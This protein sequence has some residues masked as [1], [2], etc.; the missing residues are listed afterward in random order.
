MTEQVDRQRILEAASR[1]FMEMGISKVTLDEIAEELR[2]SKKTMYRYFP[3]KDDLLRNIIHERIKRN[4]QRLTDIMT[5]G[6]PL[7]EK[8]QEIFAFVGREFSGVSRQF[9]VDL[10][11]LSP[12]LWEEAEEFRRKTIVSNVRK[13]IEQAKQEGMI[14]NELNV[15][16]FVLLFVSAVENILTPQTLADQPFSAL[17]A[18]QGILNIMFEGALTDDARARMRRSGAPPFESSIERQ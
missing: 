5:S 8:L 6:K 16:L 1:R 14:R 4:S 3:S 11:R 12:A 15:D 18:I 10:R 2:M 17:Q 7:A 9:V 13:M